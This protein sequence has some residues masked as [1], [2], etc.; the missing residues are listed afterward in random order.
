MPPRRP[1]AALLGLA[2]GL[3]APAARGDITVNFDDLGFPHGAYDPA[4]GPAPG[5]GSYDNGYD[6]NGG[7]TSHGAVFNN[8]YNSTYN[9]WG[10]WSYSNVNDPVTLAPSLPVPNPTPVPSDY[11]H[12]YAAL[13][14]SAPGGSGIYA[15]A[16]A[17]DTVGGTQAAYINL[18]A[19][20]FA[21]SFDVTNVVYTYLSAVYGDGFNGPLVRGDYLELRT[22]GY[23]GPGATG[24]VVGEA[25]T[26]L[27][28]YRQRPDGSYVETILT[29]WQSVDLSAL[30]GAQ[31]LG[32]EV[33]GNAD[34]YSNIFGTSYLNQPS[35]FAMDNLLLGTT[36]P[37]PEPTTLALISLGAAGLAMGRAAR[38]VRPRADTAA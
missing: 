7:F 25:D 31:S 21:K 19:G 35:Y 32:F 8:S 1:L 20:T 24:S 33:D 2:L 22:I 26:Y 3:V 13:P 27:A 30:K 4:Q 6:L 29:T 34:Q 18:P 5:T 17:G 28:D 36:T 37:V 38:R 9:Y 12:Q 23:S 16:D 11:T 15:V 14:G 10:G